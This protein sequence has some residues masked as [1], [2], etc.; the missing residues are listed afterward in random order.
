[1]ARRTAAADYAR[2]LELVRAAVPGIAVSTDVMAGFPGETEDEFESSIGFVASQGFSRLHVFRFSPRPGTAAAT[3][4]SQVP[5]PVAQQRSRR[6]IELAERLGRTFARR[7]LGHEVDVLWETSVPV[8][9]GLRWSGL[10]DHYVRVT[11]RTGGNVEL[12]NTVTPTAIVESD[13]ADLV[14]RLAERGQP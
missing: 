7:F 10:S 13:G 2:L 12:T 3:M 11:T 14:G 9:D 5:G 6:L 4:S 1:M 8:E